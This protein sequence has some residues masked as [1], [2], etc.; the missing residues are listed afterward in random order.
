M[1]LVR[2]GGLVYQLSDK[3]YKRM[4]T[5]I[6]KGEAFVGYEALGGK[7]LGQI[8]F[9]ATDARPMDGAY[10]LAELALEDEEKQRNSRGRG[11][12]R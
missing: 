3:S 12:K 4:V 8:S 11:R 2:D 7:Y 10:A 5:A 6:A 9:N 1:K